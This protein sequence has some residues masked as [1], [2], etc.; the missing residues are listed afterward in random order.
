[1]YYDGQLLKLLPSTYG[2]L[3]YTF[4]ALSV[5]ATLKHLGDIE[6]YKIPTCNYNLKGP[7][8]YLQIQYIRGAHKGG[9][10]LS[11]LKNVGSRQSQKNCR[12]PD[13]IQFKVSQLIRLRYLDLIICNQGDQ[14]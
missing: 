1:M 9:V 2:Q 11:V 10:C 3:F 6:K 12:I 7:L 5:T 14:C 13:H 4:Y 8:M